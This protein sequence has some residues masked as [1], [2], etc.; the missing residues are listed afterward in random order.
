[1]QFFR[2]NFRNRQEFCNISFLDSPS[3]CFMDYSSESTSDI[4]ANFPCL[5]RRLPTRFLSLPAE[6]SM[7]SAAAATRQRS[8]GCQCESAVMLLMPA[9]FQPPLHAGCSR[10]IGYS[11]EPA[12]RLGPSSAWS[13]LNGWLMAHN[14]TF[15]GICNNLIPAN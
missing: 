2:L 4:D 15:N 14:S 9:A 7:R 13:R 6:R 8:L 10:A 11:A 5:C 3:H 12:S 1:M